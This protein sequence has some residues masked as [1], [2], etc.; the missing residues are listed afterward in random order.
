[1]EIPSQ[2]TKEEEKRRMREWEEGQKQSLEIRPDSHPPSTAKPIAAG[3]P[4]CPPTNASMSAKA[5]ED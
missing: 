3:Q 4:F 1:M 5:Y 2:V